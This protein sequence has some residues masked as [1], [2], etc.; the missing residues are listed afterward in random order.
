MKR[1]TAFF[2]VIILTLIPVSA[3][4]A[5]VRPSSP[6][7]GSFDFDSIN[8][9][10]IP[11]L[12]NGDEYWE[13]F[14]FSDKAS[15]KSGRVKNATSLYAGNAQKYRFK[16]IPKNT[17]YYAVRSYRIINKKKY[18]SR[19]VYAGRL[20]KTA[21]SNLKL[22]HTSL[23][24]NIGSRRSLKAFFDMDRD[25]SLYFPVEGYYS[26]NSKIAS[27]NRNTGTLTAKAAGKC[28]ITCKLTGGY[29]A[30]CTV[31]VNKSSN[32][33][34]SMYLTYDHIFQDGSVNSLPD[35]IVGGKNRIN[36]TIISDD[37]ISRIYISIK[38]SNGKNELTYSYNAGGVKRCDLADI[39]GSIPFRDLK[40]GKKTLYV[41]VY[42]KRGKLNLFKKSF[43]VLS[44]PKTYE[45]QV[46]AVLNFAHTRLDDPYSQ[47]LRSYKRYIDCSYLVYWCFKEGAGITL[48][49]VAAY[50]YKWCVDNNKTIS[51]DELRPGDLLFYAGTDNGRYAGVN[52]VAIYIGNG[53]TIEADAPNV[54]YG[55]VPVGARQLTFARP[56]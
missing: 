26:S 47:P 2:L 1:L 34:G 25:S 44:R 54:R 42:T 53:Y 9:Y 27:V 10:Y 40:K 7:M 49:N 16:S 18:Y 45:K 48:P 56:Y 19:L 8:A 23:T 37:P 24:V 3:L 39:S 51:K 22:S 41:T 31:T 52:H 14:E 38:N 6:E 13:L 5:G 43:S 4:C 33:K 50:Q 35:Q 36:G 46:E 11:E 17:R 12:K 21:V 20:K 15:A 30:T 55:I 28:T 32:I 29:K